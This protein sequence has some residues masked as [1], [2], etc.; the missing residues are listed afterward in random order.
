MKKLILSVIYTLFLFGGVAVSG[1]SFFLLKSINAASWPTSIGLITV[2]E[3]ITSTED[4][5]KKYRTK[6]RYSY[7]VSNKHYI[8]RKVSLGS[9]STKY[10]NQG[11]VDK[12]PV[13]KEVIVYYNA[14]E[15]SESLLEVGVSIIFFYFIILGAIFII[16]A[17]IL[18]VFRARIL[19]FLSSFKSEVR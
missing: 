4:G 13:G 17:M 16:V 15:V 10:Y 5:K 12:Y 18:L 11:V 3:I 2:S 9:M 14:N 7:S 6:V 8:G 1:G 19:I